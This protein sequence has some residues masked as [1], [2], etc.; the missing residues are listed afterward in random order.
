VTQDKKRILVVEDDA[1]VAV[2]LADELIV[3]GYEVIGPAG[4]VTEATRLLR[5]EP[6]D[7]AVLDIN[8]GQETS[9]PVAEWLRDQNIPFIVVSGYT[10]HQI[11]AAYAHAPHLSKPLSNSAILSALATITQ[12]P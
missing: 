7:A 6:C 12:K 11:S 8:L 4:G 9:A 5:S 3:A 10:G 2:D 1:L